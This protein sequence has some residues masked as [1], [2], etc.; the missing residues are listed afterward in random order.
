[1]DPLALIE[2]YLSDQENGMKNLIAG[3]L[4]Q[5]MLLE[6][7][8]RAGAEHSMNEPMRGKRIG[9]ATRTEPSRPDT[10]R[11][12][13]GNPSFVS[14]RSRRRSSGAIPGLRKLW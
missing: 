14:F 12:S 9:T 1:M 5:V 3:F 13:S 2:D 6:A 7:L 11:Q 4:N 8:Q 10:G